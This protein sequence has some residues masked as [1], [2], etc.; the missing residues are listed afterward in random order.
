M[1]DRIVVQGPGNSAY[2]LEIHD[3]VKDRRFFTLYIR[4]LRE[5]M[6]LLSAVQSHPVQQ[7]ACKMSQKEKINRSSG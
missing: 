7:K 2:R 5:Y 3:F 1:S 4:A 6:N